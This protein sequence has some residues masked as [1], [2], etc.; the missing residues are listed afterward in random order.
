MSIV[1]KM[2]DLIF[3]LVFAVIGLFRS[4]TYLFTNRGTH[5]QRHTVVAHAFLAMPTERRISLPLNLARLC[6][7]VL[8]YGGLD[9]L[10]EI[11]E[12]HCIGQRGVGV[13]MR[14]GRIRLSSMFGVPVAFWA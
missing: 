13:R 3:G 14:V 1:R 10:A 5:L 2:L 11:H 7:P 8:V 9:H 12:R 6:P 4:A